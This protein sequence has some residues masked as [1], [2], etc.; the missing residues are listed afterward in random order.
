[1]PQPLLLLH[2]LPPSR[3]PHPLQLLVF[4]RLW[5]PL[6]GHLSHLLLLR[7]RPPSLLLS[8][9]HQ[10]RHGVNLPQSFKGQ[11]FKAKWLKDSRLDL[12]SCPL[13][14]LLEV[15]ALHHRLSRLPRQKISLGDLLE[16]TL[17][18]PPN[19]SLPQGKLQA[20]RLRICR[21]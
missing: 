14:Q 13:S 7:Q 8:H 3:A 19:L 10:P 2:L 20:N 15:P 5:R 17:R 1:M 11:Q 21:G 16:G 4:Q 6:I 12:L 18:R 9:H